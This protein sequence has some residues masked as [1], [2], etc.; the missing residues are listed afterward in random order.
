MPCKAPKLK[1]SQVSSE[2]EAALVLTQVSSEEDAAMLTQVDIQETIEKIN[3]VDSEI[4]ATRL[5][6]TK[7][8][9]GEL[10]TSMSELRYEND[11]TTRVR[12]VDS[13]STRNSVVLAINHKPIACT[14]D[15]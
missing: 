13:G 1:G 12:A 11:G 8:R 14:E 2:E 10:E 9:I 4:D 7:L 5:D 6:I 15:G 3:A